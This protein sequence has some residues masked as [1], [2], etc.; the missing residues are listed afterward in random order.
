MSL[1]QAAVFAIVTQNGSALHATASESAPTQA[2]LWQG[3]MLEVRGEN[4]DYLQV[5]DHRHERAGYIRA[6]R[7]RQ[8]TL[9]P[10]ESRALLEIVRFLRDS[11]GAESLG[12]AYAAAYLKAVPAERMGTEVFDA[13]GSMAERL[14]RRASAR[15]GKEEAAVITGHM[16]VVASYGVKFTTIE[17]EGRAQLCYDG[18]AF[19][20]VLAQSAVASERARAA[21]VLTDP[22]C[23]DPA[24]TPRAQYELDVWRAEVLASVD[25]SVLPEFEKNR[26]RLRDAALWSALAFQRQRRGQPSQ[27]A[28]DRA[29]VALTAVTTRELVAEDQALY[30]DAAVRVGASRWAQ[31]PYVVTPS[32][33][34]L[35][36]NVVAGQPGE[37]C[38]ELLETK[39]RQKTVLNRRCTYGIVWPASFSKH[40][41]GWA[42]ALSVQP[43]PGWRELWLFH[44][45]ADGWVVDVLPPALDEVSVGYIE[46]AGWVPGER[47]LLTAREARVGGRF[48]RK[49]ALVNIDD[50][51]VQKQA[52]QP[53]ALSRFYRWQDPAWKAQTISLR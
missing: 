38:V 4:L 7:V 53:S 21:M 14:A 40:P 17:K 36:V 27:E 10:N 33:S 52:D 26:L 43:L 29:I 2:M 42:A 3:D 28:A 1:M 22:A 12:I 9:Q 31:K 25:R 32:V 11:P 24:L 49:F 50:Q 51:S 5:Y 30:S 35:T 20:R 46:C 45:T 6:S 8:T 23:T 15:H 37:T 48:L 34:G 39:N 16:D 47:Q 44:Q 13:L 18:E 19:R 41:Q